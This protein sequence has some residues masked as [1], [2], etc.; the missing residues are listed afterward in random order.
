[1]F[2]AESQQKFVEILNIPTC[3]GIGNDILSEEQL[4]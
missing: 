4:L 1:M 3:L 2:W